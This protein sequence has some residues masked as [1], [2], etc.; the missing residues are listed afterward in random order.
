M[1]VLTLT[2]GF[3]LRTLAL[4]AAGPDDLPAGIELRSFTGWDQSIFINATETPVQAVIVPAVGGRVAHF[5][6]NGENILF[7]NAATQGKTMSASEE[8]WL[9]GYQCDVGPSMRHLPA[10]FELVQGSNQW[11][12]KG[13]FA[14]HV[15]S[16]PERQLG[17]AIEKDFL[18]APD[19]GDLGVVQRMRNISDREVSY[20]MWDRTLCKGAGF[21]FFPLNPKSRFKAG[22][23]Q[24]RQANGQDDY[25]GEHPNAP[26]ARVLDGVLVVSATGDV[27]QLGADTMAGWI[28]YARDKLLFVKYFPCYRGRNYSDGGNTVEVYIDQRAVEL[29][30]L[31]PET[32]LAP[33]EVCTFPEKWLLIPLNREITTFEEARKLVR[34]IPAMPF[35]ALLDES[36]RKAR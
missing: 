11:N 28:A 4:I 20:C 5:S 2:L 27:A 30:P 14:A 33:G 7:E 32:T 9:G 36:Q 3:L 19:T 29:S 24:R 23:S 13:N 35:R 12:L 17:I 31:S 16:P 10:H 15:S 26:Q 6:L 25:D 1:R 18:L 21:V 22:W 8:L 34:K